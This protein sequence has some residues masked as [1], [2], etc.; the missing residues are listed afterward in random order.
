MSAPLLGTESAATAIDRV[1][2]SH[3]GMIDLVLAHPMIS[4]NEIAR[5]F[6]YTVPW[7]SR[8]MCSD[9]FQA[10]LAERK[11]ELVD[12]GI[13][14]SIDE[15]LK[16][17]ATVSMEVLLKKLENPAIK[18]DAAIRIAEF[19]TKALGYGARQT[20]V[21][22]STNF[23]VALPPQAASAEAWLEGRK[24]NTINIPPPSLSLL[25]LVESGIPS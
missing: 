16:A 9:A 21:E 4:Q 11:S 14:A 20:N 15:R 13:L 8:V 23:V 6:G 5:Y 24:A 7:V 25:D 19:S 1:K 22:V 18:E 2:Y 10:R 12:P 3:D 17:L